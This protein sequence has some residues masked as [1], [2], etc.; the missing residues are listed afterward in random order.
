MSATWRAYKRGVSFDA[1]GKGEKQ[2]GE[3]AKRLLASYVTASIL[4]AALIGV[5]V[6]FG[7]QIKREVEDVVNVKFA[8]RP[9]EPKAPPPP[10]AAPPPMQVKPKLKAKS[11]GPPPPLGPKVDAV[12]TELPKARPLEGDPT[13][14][15]KAV[16]FGQGDPNGCVGCTGKP[17]GG[18]APA[19]VDALFARLLGVRG[20][21]L[22]ARERR[23]RDLGD[24]IRT[25]RCGCT[26]AA[27]GAV[28]RASFGAL[29]C[30]VVRLRC[31][32]LRSNPRSLRGGEGALRLSS[33]LRP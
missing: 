12:P 20:H 24:L 28:K 3:R 14:A 21:H 1:W 7:G 23:R 8:P 30:V 26:C 10:P 18:G 5:G 31:P 27:N 25:G 2:D 4:V 32:G 29:D 22:V 13:S 16:E 19:L 17:G 15:L 33:A 9:P 11:E 6:A